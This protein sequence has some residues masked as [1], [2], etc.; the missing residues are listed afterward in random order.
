MK[1]RVQIEKLKGLQNKGLCLVID[2]NASAKLGKNV[3]ILET[4]S[5]NIGA[6]AWRRTGV[7]TFDRNI[8]NPQKVTYDKI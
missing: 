1:R 7:L 2:H 3:Q 5:G 4:L 8:K 6:D